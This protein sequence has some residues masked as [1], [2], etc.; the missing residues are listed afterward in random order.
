MGLSYVPRGLRFFFDLGNIDDDDQHT[1]KSELEHIVTFS[2]KN[3][4][5]CLHIRFESKHQLSRAIRM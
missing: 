1:N 2:E 5:I 4:N 3:N